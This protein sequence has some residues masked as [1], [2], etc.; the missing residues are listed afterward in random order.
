MRAPCS[1]GAP[2]VSLAEVFARLAAWAQAEVSLPQLP[3]ELDGRLCDMTLGYQLGSLDIR[4]SAWRLERAG[5]EIRVERKVFELLVYLCERP[6][7][8]VSRDELLQA[9]WGR[10]VASDTVVAQAVSKLRSLL[11]EQAELADAVTTIRG[12]GYRLDATPMPFPE[13]PDLARASR[14]WRKSFPAMVALVIS[15]LAIGVLV[16]VLQRLQPAQVTPRIALLDM[17][18]ATG[19]SGLEWIAAGTTGLISQNLLQ[20][21]VD[22]VSG[23]QIQTLLAE[24]A[25]G[26]SAAE[27]LTRL[28]GVDY[29]F[30]SR[31]LPADQGFRLEL[32]T[33]SGRAPERL[34][35]TGSD[36]ATLSLAMAGRLAEEIRAP[37]PEPGGASRLNNPFLNEAY[38]RSFHH[39]QRG[40]FQAARELLEYILKEEPGF[41]WGIYRLGINHQQEG[42]FAEAVA[43]LEPLR[44]RV[45][46]DPWLAAAIRGTL[47]N[48]AWY[49]GDYA[50]AR[51]AYQQAYQRFEAAGLETGMASALGNL[52]MVANTLD[53]FA[54]GRDLVRQALEIYRRHNNRI[55]Q[56]RLLHNLGYSYKEAGDFESALLHLRQA[57]GLRQELGLQT[58]AANTLS[59]IGE[60]LVHSGQLEE[61]L[62]LLQESLEIFRRSDNRRGQG[63]VLADL[64]TAYERMGRFEEARQTAVESLALARLRNEPAGIAAVAL[65]LG[66]IER[67]LGAWALARQ[68]LDEALMLYADLGIDRGQSAALIELARLALLEG[69]PDAAGGPLNAFDS[70][71]AAAADPRHIRAARLMRFRQ[72]AMTGQLLTFDELL[73]EVLGPVDPRS[74]ERAELAA[75]MLELFAELGAN[76]RLSAELL[77]EIEPWQMRYFPAARAAYFSAR[78][79]EQCRQAIDS[80]RTLR[81]D[82]WSHGLAPQPHCS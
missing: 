10:S 76:P 39:Q 31:M 34:M 18:N 11:A 43:L 75:E 82:A 44:D 24:A 70:Q 5:H 1:I 15:V 17:E 50:A 6:G 56:A 16:S 45:D 27:T 62:A 36:P 81:G 41:A 30:S 51:Q 9:V 28:A 40:E 59:A 42:R 21:G 33:L 57:Y 7:Q 2:E 25:D 47:G 53:D 37:L 79:L 77:R 78:D 12:V 72:Q 38:A 68:Y 32:L 48:L 35:L 20:R 46:D 71:F 73:Q 61:G 55:Q 49:G 14:P 67:E 58:Q 13:A 52:G 80:L 23:R 74:P 26:E 63:V 8:V 64:A 66:R 54:L 4:V 3:L 29:V 69:K 19:D 22:V 65:L 60:I